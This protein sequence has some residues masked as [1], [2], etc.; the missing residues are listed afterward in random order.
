MNEK[1]ASIE[2]IFDDLGAMMQRGER[3]TVEVSLDG[4]LTADLDDTINDWRVAVG[5]RHTV[6]VLAARLD[7]S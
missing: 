4:R 1:D 5:L 7:E 6:S 2:G 3:L